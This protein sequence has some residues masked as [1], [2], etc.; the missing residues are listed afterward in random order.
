MRQ[1]GVPVVRAATAIKTVGRA[2]R[3]LRNLNILHAR[4]KCPCSATPAP[5]NAHNTAGQHGHGSLPFLS[6][7]VGNMLLGNA[8]G[9]RGHKCGDGVALRPICSEQG[10][11]WPFRRPSG[12]VRLVP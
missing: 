9:S 11:C 6:G 4:R 2:L 3:D 8:E 5:D 7:G 12:F 10:G 1:P